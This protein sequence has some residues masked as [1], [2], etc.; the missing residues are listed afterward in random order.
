MTHA[1][2]AQALR[3]RNWQAQPL[4]EPVPLEALPTP[5]LVLDRARFE[6]NLAV[7]RDHLTAHGKAGTGYY[8]A[9]RK[10]GRLGE[11]VTPA[12]AA[13]PARQR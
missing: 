12:P 9:K 8:F 5:A 11:E 1:Y 6:R 4:P 7:M 13:S 10:R 3:Q 2:V